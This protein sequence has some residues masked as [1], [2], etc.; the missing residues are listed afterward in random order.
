[1]KAV[2][3]DCRGSVLIL[4]VWIFALMGV[5]AAFLLYRSELEWAAVV[6]LERNLRVRQLMEEIL[7]ERLI[8]LRED[9]TAHD[10]M[11][12]PWFGDGFIQFER[13]GYE[14]TIKIEDESSKPNLNILNLDDLNR[15]GLKDKD[16]NALLDWIDID[17]ELNDEGAERDYYMTLTQPYEPRNG[18]LSTLRE[19][20]AVRNGEE[21]YQKVEPYCTVFGRYNINL[22]NDRYLE[23]LLLSA[24]FDRMWVER[25]VSDVN[26]YRITSEKKYFQS[27][28]EL[29]QLNAVSWEKYEELLPIIDVNGII[30]INFIERDSLKLILRRYGFN[31]NLADIIIRYR[32][33]QPYSNIEE[34]HSLFNKDNTPET[35]FRVQNLFTTV[36]TIVRYQIWLVKGKHTFYL[37]TVQERIPGDALVRWKIRPLLWCFLLNDEAPEIP[38]PQSIPEEEE[39]E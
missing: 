13:E 1:M 4:T 18:F 10:S 8:L 2:M 33:E 12:E 21:I 37:D 5:I 28:D 31:E 39:E 22:L 29:R 7:Q 20:M 16:A 30:N 23:N 6:N 25:M 24:G 15:L 19:V 36:T 17:D 38:E 32:M 27:I 14:V 35:A 34:L 11:D 9:E 26:D 3:R